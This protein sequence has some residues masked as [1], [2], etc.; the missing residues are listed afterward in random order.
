MGLNRKQHSSNGKRIRA[1]RSPAEIQMRRFHLTVFSGES[2]HEEPH[3]RRPY[4]IRAI[5]THAALDTGL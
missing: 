4:E 2:R 5:P 3:G 1:V